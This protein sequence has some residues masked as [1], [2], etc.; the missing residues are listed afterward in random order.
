MAPWGDP[1]RFNFSPPSRTAHCIGAAR[2]NKEMD[3][4]RRVDLDCPTESMID[5]PRLIGRVAIP[6]MRQASVVDER[7]ISG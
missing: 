2:S 3:G 5:Q 4:H 6:K 1:K 7:R